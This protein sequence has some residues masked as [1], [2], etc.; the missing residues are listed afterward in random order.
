ACIPSSFLAPIP[1]H[2]IEAKVSPS[3]ARV[4]YQ[5]D[6]G[7]RERVASP[8]FSNRGSSRNDDDKTGSYIDYSDAQ[9]APRFVKGERVR[10]PSFG[11]G[12][13]KELSGFGQDL[14]AVIDF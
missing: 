1:A 7:W 5:G 11:R 6:M 3:L 10:H 13:I 8:R 14:K 9:E 2:L 4:R 12:T